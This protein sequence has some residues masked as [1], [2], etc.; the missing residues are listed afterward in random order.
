MKRSTHHKTCNS[1][2]TSKCTKFSDKESAKSTLSLEQ[3]KLTT[4]IQ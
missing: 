4:K 2:R 3:N 1:D